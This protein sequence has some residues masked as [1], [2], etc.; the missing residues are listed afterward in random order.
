MTMPAPE[1][2][3]GVCL[4]LSDDLIFTSR[5]AGTGSPLGLVVKSA[6]TAD[7]LI[8]LAR[9]E[10][11]VCVIADLGNATLKVADFVKQLA[12]LGTPAPRIVGYGS[13][14]DAAT[15]RAAREAGCDPVLPR[16]KFVEDL[17][18]LLP[19]WMNAARH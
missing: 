14:V 9:Q 6:K 16:S 18:K 13:H 11:P 2:S 8:A 19:E 15:L 17:E 5:I 10:H 12:A 4:L 3:A 1:N 7:A